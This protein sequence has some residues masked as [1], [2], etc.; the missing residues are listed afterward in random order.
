MPNRSEKVTRTPSRHIRYRV[1]RIRSRFRHLFRKPVDSF[2]QFIGLLPTHG[3]LSFFGLLGFG[4]AALAFYWDYEDRVSRY[5]DQN[6]QRLADDIP[7]V[8]KS[9]ILMDLNLGDLFRRS[10]S[11]DG[12]DVSGRSHTDLAEFRG[13]VLTSSSICRAKFK[14]SEVLNTSFAGSIAHRAEFDYSKLKNVEL[15]GL[16]GDESEFYETIQSCVR[17]DSAS[18][19][20][21]N[22]DYSKLTNV[23]FFRADLSGSRFCKSTLDNVMFR[24][25][26]LVA[27]AFNSVTLVSADFTGAELTNAD[28]RGTSLRQA[29]GLTCKQLQKSCFDWGDANRLPVG[30]EDCRPTIFCGSANA[31]E[32]D[33]PSD[34]SIGRS[35]Q[36]CRGE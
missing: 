1:R 8:D 36:R 30:L 10:A 21:S 34:N 33:M 26:T 17:F 5:I 19:M 3:M 20:G 27:A 28:F 24:E 13:L 14:N 9:A 11:L 32:N 35:A 23:Q 6:K 7:S 25:A 16:L 15:S 22:F 12:I 31:C 4:M 18:L 29:H 2:S